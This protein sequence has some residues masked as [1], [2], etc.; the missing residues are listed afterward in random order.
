MLESSVPIRSSLLTPT[1]VAHAAF[2]PTGIVTVML[3]PLLPILSAQW[4]LTDAQAGGFF[5]AQF[6]CTTVGTVFSGVL[7]SRLGY[8]GLLVLGLAFMSLG[9]STLSLGTWLMGIGSAA[10]WGLGLGFTIPTAN[11]LVAEVNPTRRAAALN[12]LNF[13]W[14]VGA[15]SSPFL[16]APF[17]HNHHVRAFLTLLAVL[18]V[19]LAGVLSWVPL[20]AAH[21]SERA[22]G[23]AAPMIQLMLK[24][25][26]LAM[27]TLFFL[28][29]GAENAIGGWLASYAR[30][31]T[32][33][34]ILW[35]LTPSFFYTALLAGR[36]GASFVLRHVSEIRV[37]RLGIASALL[38]L[39]VV[40]GS[41]AMPGVIAGAILTG[42]G[43][44]AVYPITIATFSQLFGSASNRLGAVMFAMGGLGGATVPWLVGFVSTAFI[45]LKLGL[46]VPLAACV[47]MLGLYLGTWARSALKEPV[48]QVGAAAR[49]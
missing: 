17:L 34:G 47:A 49:E 4:S 18:V 1:A 2:I 42:L 41:R 30:R 27:A 35:P 46:A 45:S 33:G 13:S 26:A 48:A 28:Y 36:A 10:V 21:K 43:L 32:G 6:L 5:M 40:V 23:E 12:L 22:G 31:M 29:V 16:V 9:A 38:G 14:S 44:S 8:R 3:G 37:V 15:V 19:L 25:L 20:P 7:A 24:P 11:L 39:L